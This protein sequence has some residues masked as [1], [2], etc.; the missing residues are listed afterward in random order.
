MKLKLGRKRLKRPHDPKNARPR[1]IKRGAS[2]FDGFGV[3]QSHDKDM[4]CKHIQST[5]KKRRNY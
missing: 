4:P 1:T 2:L 5:S 3:C